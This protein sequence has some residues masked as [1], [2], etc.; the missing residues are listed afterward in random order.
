VGLWEQLPTNYKRNLE[1]I[2]WEGAS[3]VMTAMIV[4]GNPQP[5]DTAGI[6]RGFLIL[7]NQRLIIGHR[8]K[9]RGKP[10]PWSAFD[11]QDIEADP[12]HPQGI[13]FAA[14]GFGPIDLI[15]CSPSRGLDELRKATGSLVD[16]I[17]EAS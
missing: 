6:D 5:I 1:Q 3:A 9:F 12:D 4:H 7:T 15:L 11:L 14:P 17:A 2:I 16:P 13:V 10:E 8:S